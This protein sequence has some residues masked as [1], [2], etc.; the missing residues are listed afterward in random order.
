MAPRG[1][2]APGG[3]QE[4]DLEPRPW[5]DGLRTPEQ[6]DLFYRTY[7]LPVLAHLRY[8]EPAWDPHVVEDVAQDVWVALY[9]KIGTIVQPEAYLFTALHNKIK[10]VRRDRRRLRPTAPDALR[11][12][13][14]PPM[15]TARADRPEEM[16]ELPATFEEIQ[17]DLMAVMNAV[18]TLPHRRRD[19]YLL[20]VLAGLSSVQA[21]EILNCSTNAVDSRVCRARADL[22]AHFTTHQVA[23]FE[24]AAAEG[25]TA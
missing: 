23:L 10:N 3:D 12:Q 11:A 20:R 14:R 22:A 4:P 16:A 25:R 2:Q 18:S 13:P 7:R 5:S 21:A 8:R 9:A 1:R 19:A 15:W 6:F 24:A 17:A